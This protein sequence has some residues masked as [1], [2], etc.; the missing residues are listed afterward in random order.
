MSDAQARGI[1]AAS[2]PAAPHEL[3]VADAS[4]LLAAGRLSSVEL[5]QALLARIDAHTDLGAFLARS[6]R[7]VCEAGEL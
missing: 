5:T 1:D 3:G 6:E 2:T 7:A 4:R